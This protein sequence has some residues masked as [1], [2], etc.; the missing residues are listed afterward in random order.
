MVPYYNTRSDS[1]IIMP[2]LCNSAM[3]LLN[4]SGNSLAHRIYVIEKDE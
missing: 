2:E 1:V 4:L 3:T